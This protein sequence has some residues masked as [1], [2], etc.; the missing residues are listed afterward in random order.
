MGKFY[1]LKGQI[2]PAIAVIFAL[3]VNVL[4]SHYLLFGLLAALTLIYDP[5]GS[6][7]Y[8]KAAYSRT[9][10]PTRGRIR[11]FEFNCYKHSTLMG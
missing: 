10:Y 1:N 7:V 5:L 2:L 9:Y 3:W 4:L 8:S 6:N 11:I